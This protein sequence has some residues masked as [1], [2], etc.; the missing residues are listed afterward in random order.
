M[1]PLHYCTVNSAEDLR[2]KVALGA[3]LGVVEELRLE[4]KLVWCGERTRAEL[5]WGRTELWLGPEMALVRNR[6][7]PGAGAGQ[8]VQWNWVVLSPYPHPMGVG[9]GPPVHPPPKHSST[10]P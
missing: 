7:G 6:V 4:A 8:G 1:S 10:H 5:G 2:L 3:E 9:P